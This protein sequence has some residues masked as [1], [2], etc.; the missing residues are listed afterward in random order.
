MHVLETVLALTISLASFLAADAQSVGSV[1][2]YNPSVGGGSMLEN[3]QNG[4]GEPLNVRLLP[5]PCVSPNAGS[6]C[7]LS[8][9]VKARQ[10]F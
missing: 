7:R 9:R 1:A 8:S 5:A 2:F 10:A 4:Y 3:T 6:M